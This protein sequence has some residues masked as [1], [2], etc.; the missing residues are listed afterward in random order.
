M[1]NPLLQADD[2]EAHI[3]LPSEVDNW[4]LVYMIL[5]V[6]S[7]TIVGSTTHYMIHSN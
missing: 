4:M 3:D 7:K 6:R 2:T 1:E 5:S